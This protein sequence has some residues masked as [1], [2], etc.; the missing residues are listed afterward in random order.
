[1]LVAA[2]M[3][4]RGSTIV[5]KGEVVSKEDLDVYG[6]IEGPIWAEG[7]AITI[8][9]H[10]VVAGDLVGR[11]ITVAGRVDGTLLAV[12]VV[13]IRPTAHVN[14]RVVA[15]SLILADGGLFNGTVEP[16]QVEA[17]LSVARHRRK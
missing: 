1:M 5:I 3:G 4:L 11:D 7:H 10:A 13:D 14:A 16:Q 12:E 6:R 2:A 15:G 17:A 9:E 8:T